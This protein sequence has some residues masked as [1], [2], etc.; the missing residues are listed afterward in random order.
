VKHIS[1][2]ERGCGHRVYTSLRFGRGQVAWLAVSNAE[3]RQTRTKGAKNMKL[4]KL[5]PHLR[6][7]NAS[8]IEPPNVSYIM[9]GKQCT[10]YLPLCRDLI[11]F[12]KMCFPV[13]QCTHVRQRV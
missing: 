1:I 5:N 6:R 11:Q 13:L 7:P 3:R 4:S 9:R 12:P 10:V 8:V 2:L